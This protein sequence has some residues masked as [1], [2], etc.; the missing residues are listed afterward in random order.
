MKRVV[1]TG[2]TSI[3]GASL[4]KECVKNKIF[5]LAIVR[6][7]SKN[8]A[9]I[10]K[11]KFV[12]ILEVSLDSYKTSTLDLKTKYDTFFHLAWEHSDREFRNNCDLQKSNIDYTLDSVDLSYRL[13]CNKYVFAGS[14]AEYGIQGLLTPDTPINPNTAYGIAKYSAETFAKLKCQQLGIHHISVRI[15]SIYGINDRLDSMI[16]YCILSLLNEISP[17]LTKCEQRWD[18][19][20]SGDAGKAVKLIGEYGKNS[21]VYC[22]GSGVARPLSEYVHIIENI[23]NSTVKADIGAREYDVNSIWHLQADINNLQ[24]D[25]GFTVETSFEEGIQKTLNWI[26]KNNIKII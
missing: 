18:Y 5:V 4:I 24:K 12:D 7:N 23:V 25:T 10:P 20:F 6:K 2:A 26:L 21:S 19:L 9:R 14:Q 13:G 3:L 8:L 11:S 17:K 15:F 1:I 16:N 22:L